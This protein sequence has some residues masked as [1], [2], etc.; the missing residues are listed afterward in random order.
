MLQRKGKVTNGAQDSP[1]WLLFGRVSEILAL[2]EQCQEGWSEWGKDHLQIYAGG[3]E[4]VPLQPFRHCIM[5]QENALGLTIILKDTYVYGID[6]CVYIFWD[7][8]TCAREGMWMSKNKLRESILFLHPVGPRDRNQVISYADWGLSAARFNSFQSPG[9][10][11]V[12]SACIPP[13]SLVNTKTVP[14][15]QHAEI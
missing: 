3:C 1:G 9:C 14:I 5:P 2:L 10:K 11:A 13:T 4:P 12:L 6:V 8:L 7:M 15:P